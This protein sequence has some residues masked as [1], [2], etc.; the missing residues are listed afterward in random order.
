MSSL[1]LAVF[2]MAL[3]AQGQ[4]AAR[5]QQAHK[6]PTTFPAPAVVWEKSLPD[7]SRLTVTRAEVPYVPPTEEQKRERLSKFPPGSEL[8][9]IKHV[10]RYSF[11]RATA[12]GA[13]KEVWAWVD[14]DFGDGL[15]TGV[16]TVLDAAVE[17]DHLIVA[18]RSGTLYYAQVLDSKRDP[19]VN[20]QSVLLTQQGGLRPRMVT[21]G[22]IS[23]SLAEGT[24]AVHL[25]RRDPDRDAEGTPLTFRLRKV[26]N[27]Y[28]WVL[29]Q[30]ASK[31]AT[32]PTTRRADDSE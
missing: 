12:G 20:N 5:G 25:R 32:A 3:A 6:G 1:L 18:L 11:T 2:A 10:Y 8:G 26:N 21:G 19:L 24:L 9:E 28:Q 23:G 29:E 15:S 27:A 31:P 17:G 13:P 16:T 4:A 14:A 22:A 7:S 30:P